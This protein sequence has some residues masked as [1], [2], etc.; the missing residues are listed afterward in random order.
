MNRIILAAVIWVLSCQG[1][2]PQKLLPFKLPDSGQTGSFTATK[3]ED[4]DFQ[5]NPPSLID[6]G[7]GTIT[8]N[9]TGLMWQKTDGG[10]MTFESASAYVKSLAVGGYTDWR[11]PTC[12]ELFS[13]NNYSN[14][15]PA[16]NTV[17]FTKSTAEYWW[18]SERRIDDTTKIWVVNAGGGV[19]PH[20]KSETVSAGGAKKFHV[21]A[22]RN[23]FSTTFSVTHFT[24]N[25]NG[26][27]R[28]NYTGLTW[29]KI[30][31]SVT[32][33]WEEALEYASSLSLAGKSDWRVPN[34]KELQ[35]LNDEKLCKPSINNDY[36]INALSGS[37][38]SST[39]MINTTTVAWDMNV[40]YGIVSYND[41]T[42]KE[43]VLLVR[44][45]MDNRDLNIIDVPIPGGSFAMGDH[46]GFV[47]P[48]H[49]SDE[50]PIHIVTLD[51]FY[52]TKTGITN[53]QFLAF[54]NASILAGTIEVK[55][56]IVYSTG[57]PDSICFTN[58]YSSPYS[59]SFDGKAFTI[60]DFRTNHP[61]VGVIWYGILAYCNWL[62]LRNGLQECYTL[63][64]QSCDFTKTGYRLPT[65]AEREYSARGGHTNPYFNYTLGNAIDITAMNLPGSG[66]PYEPG[67]YPNTTPAGF[68][69]GKLKLKTEYNWPGNAVSYQ[70]SDGING[71]GLYDMQGNVWEYIND[72][73]GT[74]YYSVSPSLNPRGPDTGSA[75][76]DGKPYR[77]MR[78]GNWYN[79]LVTNGINDGHSR[80]SNRDPAYYRGPIAEKDSWSEVGFRVVRK[81][82]G[83]A[84]V[85]NGSGAKH[86][87]GLWLN[88]NY[89]NPFN[90]ETTINFSIPIQGHVSLKVYNALGQELLALIDKVM[91]SGNYS[92]P[93]RG[94][95]FPSGV[96]FYKLQTENCVIVKK[97]LLIK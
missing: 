30:Q 23:L 62:S 64:T 21:R 56:G 94:T 39:T 40:D 80:V 59:I 87:E 24:D 44:G 48:S 28:D 50:L 41:K 11:L 31:S 82:L 96:L 20:P 34:V 29:Q 77:G 9:V 47:D 73:Y 89:P 27:I 88:Q 17:F 42:V 1:I 76:P 91:A 7:D 14:L 46:F 25:G 60:V 74:N 45:G 12:H 22:V 38:W 51:S 79:G 95:S 68:Y 53:Q 70:T 97:M 55:N 8:D 43:N 5:I 90:P 85:V 75:M 63:N 35:S 18:G 36:F 2:F 57:T 66:D 78:G 13:I 6:N 32:M 83:N 93:F 33:S 58:Q 52:M 69:D 16:L 65:E 10:E 84:S 67:A 37:F 86:P 61:V 19:G 54:L 71:F 49:P 92:I 15:N 4:A 3:G 26:T 81:N 72:W